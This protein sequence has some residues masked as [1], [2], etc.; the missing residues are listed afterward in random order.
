MMAAHI[1]EVV[2]TYCRWPAGVSTVDFAE[3]GLVVV[4]GQHH[5][6]PVPLSLLRNASHRAL[7][8][9]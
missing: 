2:Q 9:H 7:P 8:S 3:P 1:L 6:D 4:R 5:L